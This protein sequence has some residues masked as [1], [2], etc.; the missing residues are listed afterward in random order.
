MSNQGEDCYFFFY[1]TCTKGDSCPFRHCEAAL[2][3][4]TVCTLWQEGRCFRQV[5]RFRHMEIDKKRSEIPCYW[6][7]QPMGCQKLNCAF[8]H[9]RGRYVEGLFLPPSKT[10][11]PIVPES[12]DEEVKTSQLSM[13]QNKLSV[14]S[15]PSPQLR[16]VMKVESSENV[17][18]PTHPPVVINAADDDEDDDDQFS[19]E[20][21]ETKTPILQPSPEVHNGLRITGA[22]KPGVSLKQGD[23]LNFGIKTLEEIKSKKMKEKSKKQGEGPSGASAHL[24]QAQPIPGPE[25]ENV[26]T[27]VRTVTLSNKQGEEPLVR[28]SLT[29]RLGKRKLSSIDSDPP[30]KRSLAQRLG[31]KIESPEMNTDKT[32]K[33]VQVSKSLK[34]RLGMP[35]DLNSMETTA[36]RSAKGGE[37][38][39]KTLEE[40]RLERASQKRGDLQ[41]KIKNEGPYKTEDSNL[42]MK[43]SSAIR[44][45]T[46]SEVLAEKKHRQQEEERQKAEKENPSVKLRIESESK[47]PVILPP[48]AVSKG[49]LEEPASKTKPMQEVHIKTLEEIKQEK[50]LRVQQSAENSTNSQPQP[51]TTPVIRRLLRITKRTGIKEEKKLT[52]A[53]E[54]T[55]R[56]G[57][58]RTEAVEVFSQPSDETTGDGISK[59][60]V[61]KFEDIMREKR[62]Q[63]Q[64]E[65]EILQKEKTVLTPLQEEA[66][67]SNTQMAEKSE[68]IA[69][70]GITRQQ[71]KRMPMKAQQVEVETSG[72]GDSILNVKCAAQPLEKRGK[73]K[74]KVNVKPSVVKVISA[75]KLATKRKAAEVHPAVIAA[76]KP[77]SSSCILQENPSKKAAVAAVPVLSE[78]KP[79]TV[80]ETEKTPNSLDLPP[81]QASSDPLPPE[82]SSPSSSQV[83]TKSR[84][85]SSAS[86]GK[87]PLSVE[88]DFEKLIWEISG[89]KLEAEIDLDPGKDEDDLLL[90]LSEMIDS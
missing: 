43:S 32:P 41:T 38:H 8:H 82:V 55:S 78:D 79:V 75:P 67:P 50:A 90:E 12:P 89:G 61:K 58:N 63:K 2:G 59:V 66:A 15:N 1:S 22:R 11:L 56:L 60:Q 40:I 4:E 35:A 16:G 28:L 84:R 86:S 51:E 18:S 20:G 64:Q 3:N 26:R 14:P 73:A 10:I 72:I 47:K 53:G 37:I 44:I 19:E 34:E 9:N 71:T 88:D 5:C 39:V 62:I 68:L 24:L 76:V 81:S 57:V 77:L 69:L 87:P 80:S 85:L 30:L 74:P 21:D 52:E 42:G 70:P 27:V 83:V 17:P 7:N 6:E 65:V 31:K 13:Q 36:E 25:K 46:F 45:K 49:Q 54:T 48:T 23:S 29:E 33:K